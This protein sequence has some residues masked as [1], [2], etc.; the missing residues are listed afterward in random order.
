MHRRDVRRH[1]FLGTDTTTE[2]AWRNAYGADGYDIAAD[3]SAGNPKIPSYATLSITG[4]RPMSGPP[5][6]PTRGPSRTRPNTGRIAAAWYSSSTM[7]FNLNLTD[8]KSHE[9]SLYAVDFDNKS[10]SEEVQVIDAA[11]GTVL[12]TQTLSSFQGGEYLSWNLSGNVVIKVTNLGPS[13]TR[14]SAASS[15]VASRAVTSATFLGTDTTTQGSWHGVYGADGYDIAADT[16]AGNPK[17]PSYATLSITGAPTYMWAASTTDPRALQ[18][19]ANT[20][21]IA[22]T[23]YSSS[24]MSFNLNLTDGKSHK[25]S[26][27]AVDCD[28]HESQRAGPGHRRG[29]RDG[30]EHA[31]DQLVPGRRVPVVEPSRA[32]W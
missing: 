1:A 28:S 16:S 5:T 13:A 30:A 32:T 21:R 26:L 9:V 14:S 22:S 3:T 20:G 6:R 18:N 12:D 11:T 27:Y 15:S 8:G 29:D 24:T 10:R 2:G 25:V 23:W 4:A 31:D 7:S 19:A 17:I